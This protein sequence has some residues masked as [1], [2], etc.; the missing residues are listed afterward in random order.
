MVLWWVVSR[1]WRC[2]DGVRV[3]AAMLLVVCGAVEVRACCGVVCI[4][5][6]ECLLDGVDV[7]GCKW[8]V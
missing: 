6:A 3:C 2:A 1:G 7:V 5:F 4:A 8:C